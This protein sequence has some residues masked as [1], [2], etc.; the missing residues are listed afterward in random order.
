VF[1]GLAIRGREALHAAW[2]FGW[3]GLRPALYH[4][5]S[6]LLIQL[7]FDSVNEIGIGKRIRRRLDFSDRGF[8]DRDSSIF[9]RHDDDAEC[10][11][12]RFLR[13]YFDLQ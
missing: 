2:W 1:E 8:D 9:G 3:F 13:F 11:D 5:S 4:F 12:R 7:A 6:P 10:V